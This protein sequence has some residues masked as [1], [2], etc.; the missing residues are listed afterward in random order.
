MNVIPSISPSLRTYTS[1]ANYTV[2]PLQPILCVHCHK[3]TIKTKQMNDIYYDTQQKLIHT[4]YTNVQCNPSM[5]ASSLLLK[6]VRV[7]C[8]FLYQTCLYL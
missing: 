1:F 4:H 8:A 7:R 2:L 6:A 5:I 3:D